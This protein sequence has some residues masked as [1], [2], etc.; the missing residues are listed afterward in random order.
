MRAI[1]QY[2]SICVPANIEAEVNLAVQKA[3]QNDT[4]VDS[5]K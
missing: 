5:K 1:R 2:A 3:H 4:K